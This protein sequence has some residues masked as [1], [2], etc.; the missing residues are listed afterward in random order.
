[1]S[2]VSKLFIKTLIRSRT[3]R[4]ATFHLKSSLPLVGLVRSDQSAGINPRESR[5]AARHCGSSF[6]PGATA[7]GET[8]LHPCSRIAISAMLKR[9]V[10]GQGR[11]FPRY[12][13]IVGQALD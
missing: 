1:M 9:G 5:F 3:A 6:A 7:F 4:A 2:L 10:C 11:A 13:F 12:P 8:P